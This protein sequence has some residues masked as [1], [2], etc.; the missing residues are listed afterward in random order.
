MKKIF[1]VAVATI[2]CFALAGC[3]NSEE[4]NER[5]FILDNPKSGL[6][7]IVVDKE[8][9]VMYLLRKSDYGGGIT[10]LL[11]ADGKPLIYEGDGNYG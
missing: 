7:S 6:Y 8:T 10:A 9:C 2:I 4:I 3:R 5:F 1:A 11:D